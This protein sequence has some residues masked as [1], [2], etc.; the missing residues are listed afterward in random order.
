M[1]DQLT[2]TF[3]RGLHP[4]SRDANQDGR[5]GAFGKRAQLILQVLE[6]ASAPLT[7]RQVAGMLGFTD[8]NAV[9]PRI[10]ECIKA[11]YLRECKETTIDEL[12]GKRVRLV[13]VVG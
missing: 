1:S 12:T 10:S 4:N 7:D 2:L 8:M 3:P 11:G 6:Q 5:R 9:R 13:E